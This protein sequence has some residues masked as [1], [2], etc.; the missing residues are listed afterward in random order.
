MYTTKK[1]S[2]VI[3]T[4]NRPKD[5]SQTLKSLV[6]LASL[7]C[8]II[9]VDQ[10]KN[11]DTKN[12]VN[13]LKKSNIRYFYSSIPSITKARNL[14]IKKVSKNA[15]LVCF[16]DDDVTLDISYFRS[17]IDFF[18]KN[19]E[20]IALGGFIP[21]DDKESTKGIILKKI[22]FLGRREKERSVIVS[23]YGNI[24][25]VKLS[26]PVSAQWLPGVNM[27]YKKEVFRKQLF[28]ENLLGY[29]VA[30]DI[31]FS[32]RLYKNNP[33]RIFIIP[34][35]VVHRASQ[36]E[37]YP[38]KKMSYV[39]QIDHFYF[40]I[41]NLKS[42]FQNILLAWSLTGI[43]VMRAM[44]FILTHRKK[45]YLKLKFFIDSLFY[46]L[47]HLKDIKAGKLRDFH[48]EIDKIYK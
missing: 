14:G 45:E 35:K 27:V 28:D 21:L 31:D 19:P 20:A 10:S 44:R 11:E 29:T 12:T 23:A 8:E 38:A 3:P 26:K 24:Y 13:S 30:E 43:A 18:N 7:L 48:A 16:I 33:G 46:S 41:K 25:P 2:V 40:H 22:F 17:V 34:A 4:Y 47:T 5:V 39:N 32:Y 37:R 1:I 36:S 42:P 15:G 9:I 6:P